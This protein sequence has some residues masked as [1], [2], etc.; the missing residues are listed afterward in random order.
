MK[1]ILASLVFLAMSAPVFAHHSGPHHGHHIRHGHHWNHHHHQRHWHR[2][3]RWVAPLVI[4][5]GVTYLATRPAPIIVPEPVIVEQPIEV[6]PSSN[7][8]PWREVQQPDGTIV[9]ER[10]CYSR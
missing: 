4:G 1:K 6:T 10:T 5:A 2:D 9:R 7:C 3:H 8:S